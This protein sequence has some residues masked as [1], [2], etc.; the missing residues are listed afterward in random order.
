[1]NVF[2]QQEGYL[3]RH[4]PL[5][6]VFPG[7]F[8]VILSLPATAAVGATAPPGTGTGQSQGGGYKVGDKV[9]VN[10][11]FGW[12]S[13]QI[14]KIDGNRYYVHT[15]AGDIWKYYPAEVRSAGAPTAQDRA[16][17]H[18][19]LHDR[20]QVHVDGHWESGEI[21]TT[22]G[23]EYQIKLAGNRETWAGPENMKYAGAA[24]AAPPAAQGVP[25]KSGMMSCAGKIEGRYSNSG[26]L[27]SLTIVF[28]SGKATLADPSG[29]GEVLECWMSGDK[30][31]LHKPGQTNLDMPISINN[32]GTLDT[33]LGEIKKKG[34]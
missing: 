28:R 23:Q 5:R 8:A 30:I 20:V 4:G 13:A 14:L 31:I 3:M 18:Y 22:M 12:I 21:V 26:G 15:G 32:D 6:F 10:T 27:G 11:G 9:Q 24:A 2:I 1:M 19:Q 25:P 34:N 29:Q 16:N 7:I 17:G 33:P